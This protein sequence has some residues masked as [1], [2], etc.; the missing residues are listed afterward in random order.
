M[1]AYAP[2][3]RRQV[4]SRFT[5]TQNGSHSV[6]PTSTNTREVAL[7]PPM[8]CTTMANSAASRQPLPR[9][10]R[11]VKATIQGRPDHGDATT[12]CLAA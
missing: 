4:A 12:E 8:S 11:M 10:A 9:M 3:A 6:V 7:M 2:R 1:R 5:Q